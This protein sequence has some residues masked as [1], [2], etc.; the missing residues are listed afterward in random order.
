M[1][2]VC[3]TLLVAACTP[4][5]GNG[6]QLNATEASIDGAYAQGDWIVRFNAQSTGGQAASRTWRT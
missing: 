4:D 2:A 5:P 6:L 1:R 3:L